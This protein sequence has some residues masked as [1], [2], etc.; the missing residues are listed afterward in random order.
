MRDG[1]RDQAGGGGGMI[2]FRRP[3]WSPV[4]RDGVE[5]SF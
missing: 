3:E 1:A 5:G 2:V 4:R